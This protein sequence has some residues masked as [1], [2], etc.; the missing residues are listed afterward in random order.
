MN[1]KY[2]PIFAET[3][4]HERVQTGIPY[5]LFKNYER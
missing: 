4:I 5:L 2:M 1:N 3:L